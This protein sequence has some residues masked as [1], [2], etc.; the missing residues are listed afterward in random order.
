M[1]YVGI[2][3]SID[4]NHMYFGIKMKMQVNPSIS[5]LALHLALHIQTNI[6]SI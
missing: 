1:K 5:F 3:N 6:H 4:Q 2:S